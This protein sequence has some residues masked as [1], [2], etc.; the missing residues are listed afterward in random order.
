MPDYTEICRVTSTHRNLPVNLLLQLRH[1]VPQEGRD[2]FC[3]SWRTRLPN[4]G[5]NRQ[6]YYIGATG[7]WKIP[8][9]IAYRLLNQAHNKGW[10]NEA[11]DD[12]QTRH[13]GP[14]NIVIDSRCLDR[15]GYQRELDSIIKIDWEDID[16]DWGSEPVFVIIEVPDTTWRKIMV[17]D[18]HREM[19][20]F[21]SS[22]TDPTYHKRVAGGMV[23]PWGMDNSMQDAS[24]AMMRIFRQF[25]LE[26][27]G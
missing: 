9:R 2:Y 18:T 13:G 8:V 11:F 25:L 10:L 7:V 4:G 23:L 5:P 12:P 27:T 3:L 14:A 24:S 16:L 17:I 26:V 20:T 15:E 22:T 19:C 21:R 1:N 6:G